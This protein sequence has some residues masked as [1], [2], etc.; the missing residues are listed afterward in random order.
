MT[1]TR[2]YA[3]T[4]AS[5]VTAT[6]RSRPCETVSRDI[7]TEMLRDSL[8]SSKETF[9]AVKQ[10]ETLCFQVKRECLLLRRERL[11][12]FDISFL[13]T[14]PSFQHLPPFSPYPVHLRG[15]FCMSAK[16]TKCA[17]VP[18]ALPPECVYTWHRSV[19]VYMASCVR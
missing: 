2:R 6:R 11:F 15:K 14:P 7:D 8:I 13:S 3:V 16:V 19:S 5:R 4:W 18:S 17:R 9:F 10:R 12:A 1:A